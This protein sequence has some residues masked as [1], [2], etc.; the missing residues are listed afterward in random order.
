[1]PESRGNEEE[2]ENGA[3]TPTTVG[4]N[5]EPSIC[6]PQRSTPETGSNIR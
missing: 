3:E 4:K 1:M 2:W 6:E 5:S